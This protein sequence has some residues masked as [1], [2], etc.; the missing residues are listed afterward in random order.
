MSSKAMQA[1]VRPLQSNDSESLIIILINFD[2]SSKLCFEEK[3][4]SVIGDKIFPKSRQLIF[5]DAVMVSVAKCP[6]ILSLQRV[7]KISSFE[8]KF[9]R[10]SENQCVLKSVKKVQNKT[11]EK[12]V[13]V[14]VNLKMTSK[15]IC[16]KSP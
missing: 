1:R 14:K 10:E 7:P 4:N 5:S 15:P 9:Q 8:P 3:S 12:W 16:T 2:C 11:L 13:F 6:V